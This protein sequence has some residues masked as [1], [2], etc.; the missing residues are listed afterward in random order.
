MNYWACNV[1]DIMLKP[2]GGGARGLGWQGG[3]I[4]NSPAFVHQLFTRPVS[5]SHQQSP[6]LHCFSLCHFTHPLW[7][8]KLQFKFQLSKQIAFFSIQKFWNWFETQQRQ[9]EIIYCCIFTTDSGHLLLLCILMDWCC[10]IK[11]LRWNASP[12]P[13]PE[14]TCQSH[15][16]AVDCVME[17]CNQHEGSAHVKIVEL[18]HVQCKKRSMKTW[19]MR[20]S[21]TPLPHEAF[22][23]K[24]WM[25]KLAD[26]PASP[27][28]RNCSP[29]SSLFSRD[30]DLLLLFS[31]IFSRSIPSLS[32][33]SFSPPS[34]PPLSVRVKG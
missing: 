33:S 27:P 13:A 18:W 19:N 24:A 17:V 28:L 1:N 32:N 11:Q 2:Q 25:F 26:L 14:S 22:H 4:K 29:R 30:L 21:L 23:M 7:M 8:T 12:F 3:V 34:L 20:I 6:R 5:R 10:L 31:I 16:L 15:R 9:I